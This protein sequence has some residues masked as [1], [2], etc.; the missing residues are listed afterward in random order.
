MITGLAG[1]DSPVVPRLSADIVDVTLE[2]VSG[3]LRGSQRRTA[4]VAL[5]NLRG[6]VDRCVAL[7][8]SQ[9]AAN[10]LPEILG[11]AV[12][13]QY[14]LTQLELFLSDG[15][16][17]ITGADEAEHFLSFIRYHLWKLEHLL[18]ESAVA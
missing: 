7:P 10:A 18:R 12:T 2:R 17:D 5:R 6:I 16:S 14:P 8:P 11:T 9:Y 13:L 1:D 4:A 15:S 3:G